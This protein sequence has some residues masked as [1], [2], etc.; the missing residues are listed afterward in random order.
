MI[1]FL[2]LNHKEKHR[3]DFNNLETMQC[4]K[5]SRN[6]TSLMPQR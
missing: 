6:L 3:L 2:T 4:T 1:S 5:F